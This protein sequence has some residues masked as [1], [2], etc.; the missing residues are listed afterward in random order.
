MMHG[1]AV[2]GTGGDFVEMGSRTGDIAMGNAG[3]DAYIVGGGDDG[4]INEIGNLMGG[5]VSSEDSIQFEL[6]NDMHE[7]DFTRTEDRW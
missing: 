3:N 2:G 5:G 1:T 4:I 7:L 6:V